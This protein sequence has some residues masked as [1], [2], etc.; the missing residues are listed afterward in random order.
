M[1]NFYIINTP[2]LPVLGNFWHTVRKFTSGF[3][4]IGY[5]IFIINEDS[6]FDS[7]TDDSENFFFIGDHGLYK[8]EYPITIDNLKKFQ[9][10]TKIFW[11]FH[12][13][14]IKNQNLNL[15][16]IILTGEHFHKKPTVF[17]HEKCYNFQQKIDFYHPL[18]FLSYVPIDKI[19]TLP[20]NE[21]WNAQF[22]GH[23]YKTEWTS[24]LNNC[25]IRNTG[26]EIPEEERI[27]SFLWS[28]ISLGFSSDIN[29]QNSVVT[30]RVAEGLSLGNVIISDNPAA[31]DW[32]E[33][34]VEHVSTFDE[35]QER[36][37]Y[38]IKDTKEFYKKQKQG[39]EWAKQKG[40]YSHLALEFVEKSKII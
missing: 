13:F 38:Y 36:I 7:I 25:F 32:T 12:E 4:N 35:L 11:F 9:K 20:R 33:G 14:F 29:I 27:K 34:L 22:V 2:S 31:T 10:T 24:K 21:I 1:K 8:S 19:G 39:Y 6:A 18:T 3:Q 26:P 40:T 15:G 5:K 30:E 16:K 28:Y 17:K 37:S 23:Y